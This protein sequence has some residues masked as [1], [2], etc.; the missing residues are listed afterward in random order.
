MSLKHLEITGFKSFAKKSEFEFTA[1][2]TAIVGPNG[3][4]KSNVAEAFRFVLG[5]QSIKSL[6]GKKGED[7]IF[8]GEGAR[9]NRAAVKVVFANSLQG[10]TR[11]LPVDFD[12][13]AIE[14][15]VFRDGTNEY[16]I[17]GSK[18][19]LKDVTELLASANIGSSGHHIISQGEADRV[20]SASPKERRGMIEDALGLR[21]YQYKK[22]ESEKKLARTEENKQ[23]VASLR[24]ENAPHLKFLERQM[25]KINK[26]LEL[27]QDL[28]GVYK[29]YLRRESSY[30][31][32]EQDALA[33]AKEEP[34]KKEQAIASKI[35][36][37]RTALEAVDQKDERRD[38][39]LNLENK[40]SEVRTSLSRLSR[41]TGSLEGQISFEERRLKE[42]ERKAENIEERPIIFGEVK[43]F[44]TTLE[45][46]LDTLTQESEIE[47]IKNR[48]AEI[49]TR[50]HEFIQSHTAKRP[51]LVLDRTLLDG[52]LE[53]QAGL[54]T[55]LAE[56]TAEEVRLQDAYKQLQEALA[57]EKDES[58]AQERELFEAMQAHNDVRV[59]LS[60]L[61]AREQK[62]HRDRE[63]FKRELAEAGALMGRSITDYESFVIVG[64]AGQPLALDDLLDEDRG[65]QEERRRNLERMKIRLEELGGSN[66]EE[67]IEEYNEV[68]ERDA[69]LER[70]LQDLDT[71]SAALEQLIQDLD[72]ELEQKFMDGIESIST[73]FNMFFTTMFGG[74]R[75][76]L[77]VVRERKRKNRDALSLSE[78][79]ELPEDDEED[80]EEGERGVEVGVSL[81]NKRVKG[82]M[83]LSGGERALTS[84]ALI[85]AMSQVNPPPFLILDE[86]DAALDEA[87]SKRYADMIE[88]LAKHSQLIV[89]THNRETMSRAGILYG[90]TMGGDGV[91]KLLSV[92]FEEGI[93]YAK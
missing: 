54:E 67:V 66:S 53:S 25:Q 33:A 91:S 90:V 81:P 17:N 58:R 9:A 92:K 19:R 64:E 47:T 62:L 57:R 48:L 63:E 13:V 28:V 10:E 45:S 2:I 12:E 21:V 82:L 75:A 32:V 76:S 6:R 24:R 70:E 60:Q 27:K 79:G 78:E 56:V 11:L 44:T 74:G 69:F 36:E 37:L 41:E 8:N 73:A 3:S 71:T 1:S 59:L 61:T 68:K 42:E 22:N 83:M 14:R 88:E 20:L 77:D 40:L 31:S 55:E 87:N 30:L 93:E 52:L 39:I 35:Q 46:D 29:E 86:T 72:R 23:Q 7:L 43:N 84:I 15:S 16:A 65:R 34:L 51:E 18:V 85:F 38:E 49:K 5:E 89:I 4:G 80:T 26:A 50:V